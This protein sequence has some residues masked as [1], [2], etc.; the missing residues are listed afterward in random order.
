MIEYKAQLEKDGE[1]VAQI[2]SYSLEG[3]EEQLHKLERVEKTLAI[4]EKDK[5]EYDKL[6]EEIRKEVKNGTE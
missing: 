2:S 3:L 4:Y 5:E 6:M 1:I